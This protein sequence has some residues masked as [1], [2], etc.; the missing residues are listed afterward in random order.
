MFQYFDIHSHLNLK[1]LKKDA[2]GIIKVLE[3]E[4]IGTITIGANLKTSQNAV[5]LS[6]KSKNL[7]A[8]VGLHPT[9]TSKEEFSVET[10][11]KLA[12]QPKVVCIG[13][14]GLDYFRIKNNESRIKNEQKDAFKKHIE[15]ALELDLPLM[16]HIRPTQSTQDAYEDALQILN[17]YFLIHNSKLRGNTHFFA[18]NLEIARKFLELG[19]TISFAGPITFA[20]DYDEIV[21]YVPLDMILSETD[22]PFAA[23][24][25]YRGKR[26][27]PQYVKEVVKKIAEIRGDD[28][29]K[30]KKQLVENAMR[31]FHG[32]R[33]K[34]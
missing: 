15:L 6:Q 25:P 30:V 32:I 4:N 17:S 7:F 16:L 29:E 3:K 8:G 23:P 22:A 28:L 21:C 10:Y 1:P 34:N 11:R 18:G 5:E 24:E 9:D 2:D 20:R 31:V 27:E 33:T 13:E 12:K 26:N 14:C 19:F